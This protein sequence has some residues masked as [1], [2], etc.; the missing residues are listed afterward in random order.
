MFDVEKITKKSIFSSYLAL[1]YTSVLKCILTYLENNKYNSKVITIIFGQI[2]GILL[3][4]I[5][6]GL[7]LVNF[8]KTKNMFIIIGFLAYSFLFEIVDIILY[9]IGNTK[10]FVGIYAFITTVKILSIGQHFISQ[11]LTL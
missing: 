11:A 2:F 10:D 7:K 9:S 6:N 4:T 8:D 1:I 5:P 3:L